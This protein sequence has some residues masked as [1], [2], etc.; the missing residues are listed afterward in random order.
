MSFKDLS[1]SRPR[2]S[3]SHARSV[4]GT[5]GAVAVA[6]GASLVAQQPGLDDRTSHPDNYYA[7]GNRI[8]IATPMGGDVVVAGRHVDITQPVTGDVL[9]A[10]WR[11]ALSGRAED[12]VRV[13][14]GEVDVNAPIAGDLTVAGG[15]VTLGPDTHV[16]G[17]GWITGRT[18]R[19]N[20]VFDRNLDV[21]GATVQVAGEIRKPVRIVAEKLEILSSAHILAPLTYR[22]PSEAQIAEGAVV[23]G[24]V[25]FDRIAEREARRGRAFPAASMVLFSIHLFL[26]GILVV[27]FLPRVEQSVVDTLR[28]QPGKSLLAGFVLLVTTPVA[29]ALLVISILGLP[30]GLA[31]GALYAM[32]LFAGVLA[33]AFFVG[34]AEAKLFKFGPVGTRGQHVLLLLASVLTLAVLRSVFGGL[35][36]F[37]STL[38]GLGAVMLWVYREGSRASTPTSA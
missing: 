20:G 21:A 35:V 37:V 32:A 11:V 8:D 3:S 4:L 12:D 15:D 22:A 34:D 2:G 33:T 30:I 17:R 36:V 1:S 23:S 25:T 6:L 13:A 14:A 9:A 19:I 31:L 29:A 18:V 38:F 5:V 10:G 27:V 26:A 24:P 16:G 28:A 7:A